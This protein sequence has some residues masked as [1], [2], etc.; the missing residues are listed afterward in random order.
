[1]HEHEP[2]A[3]SCRFARGPFH[4]ERA[5]RSLVDTDDNPIA[6][7]LTHGNSSLALVDGPGRVLACSASGAGRYVPLCIRQGELASNLW[8]GWTDLR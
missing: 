8:S 7:L 2:Q 3:S 6:P 1:V 5:L 4:G